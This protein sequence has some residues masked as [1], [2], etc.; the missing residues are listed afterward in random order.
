MEPRFRL[1]QTCRGR[2][3]T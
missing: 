3:R 2:N 1:I